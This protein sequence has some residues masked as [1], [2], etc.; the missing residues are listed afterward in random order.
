MV[1]QT[2]ATPLGFIRDLKIFVHGISYMITF[3]VINSNVLDYNYSM[4]LGCPWLK[5]AKVSHDWGTNIVTIQIT[6]IVKTI[7]VNKKLSVQTKR[8]QVLICYDC[9]FRISNDEKDVMFVTELN[10]FPIGT[11]VVPTHIKHVPKLVC[12]LDI[13]MVE[14]VLKQHV[15]LI[16]VL[17]MKLTIQPN[18][19]KQHL[20]ETFFHL[21]VGEVLL[22][23]API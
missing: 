8:L 19:I 10:M 4:L 9:H 13:V 1:D 18:T 17:A 11:I 23:D 12:I 15:K 21:E 16:D 6:N 2:I 22:D 3:T 5:D 20:F 7:H 14:L